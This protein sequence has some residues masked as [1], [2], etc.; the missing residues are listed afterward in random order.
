M[1]EEEHGQ[2]WWASIC[3]AH[4]YH[5]PTCNNCH[6][7]SWVMYTSA[8]AQVHRTLMFK[9]AQWKVLRVKE[10]L[11]AVDWSDFPRSAW[12]VDYQDIFDALQEI[13]EVVER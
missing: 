12:D 11:D 10:I 5:E 1:N 4:Q 3:S 7:G 8:E 9:M 6:S 13:K 2:Y